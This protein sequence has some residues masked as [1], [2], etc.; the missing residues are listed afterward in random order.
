MA[1]YS[2]HEDDEMNVSNDP[3]DLSNSIEIFPS[4]DMIPF[5]IMQN[6]ALQETRKRN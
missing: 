5:E 6:L 2:Y 4:K 1:D 3:Y